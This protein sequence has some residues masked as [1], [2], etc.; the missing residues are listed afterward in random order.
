[1][2]RIPILIALV[3]IL[4]TLTIG[5]AAGSSSSAHATVIDPPQRTHPA[6]NA[7][8]DAPLPTTPTLHGRWVPMPVC[9]LV[10]L[11]D[12]VEQQVFGTVM[13]QPVYSVQHVCRIVNTWIEERWRNPFNYHPEFEGRMPTMGSER[14][15]CGYYY[16]LC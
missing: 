8:T 16:E 12:Y 11:V 13:R 14:A 6:S 15:R 1:M 5:V 7:V 2:F 4:A 10:K 3:A 9:W